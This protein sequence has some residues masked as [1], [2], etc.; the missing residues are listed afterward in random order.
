MLKNYVVI[1]Y[2][3]NSSAL[4]CPVFQECITFEDLANIHNTKQSV[5]MFKSTLFIGILLGYENIRAGKWSIIFS[6]LVRIQETKDY[7]H[8]LRK[9]QCM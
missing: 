7:F 5:A 2:T 4:I 8:W 1:S 3:H 6:A 9:C